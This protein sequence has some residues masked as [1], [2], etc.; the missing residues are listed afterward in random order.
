MSEPSG[1]NFSRPP[2]PPGQSSQHPAPS[3]Q[4]QQPIGVNP[5]DVGTGT[6]NNRST[7]TLY[8]GASAVNPSYSAGPPSYPPSSAQQPPLWMHG[9]EQAANFPLQPS[10]TRSGQGRGPTNA[11]NNFSQQ[12][13][14]PKITRNLA[15]SAFASPQVSP[16]PQI[17]PSPHTKNRR[18]IY[19]IR[20]R[21]ERLS[22][23]GKVISI[24]LLIAIL[25]PSIIGIFELINGIILYNQVKSGVAHIQAIQT[26][27]KG[28]DNADFSKY[29]DPTKL[30]QA[31]GEMV[32]AHSDFSL[33]SD[34]LDHDGSIGMTGLL[35]PSQIHAARSLGH[36]AM[37]ATTIGER[38]ITTATEQSPTMVKTLR[39]SAADKDT[40]HPKPYITQEAFV[41]FNQEL[42][43]LLPVIKDM[44]NHSQ[45]LSLDG[46]PLSTSQ[47]QMISALLPLIPTIYTLLSQ[48]PS[49]RNAL[50]W[51]IGADQQ[52][53]FLLEPMDSAELRSTGGFTGQFGEL[54]FN[55]G[56]MAKLQMKNIGAY[57]EDHSGPPSYGSLP[58]D[59]TL[60]QKVET[61]SAPEP[62]NA[63]WPIANFGVRDANVSGDFPTT[64]RIIMD[65]YKG[66]FGTQLSG[67]ILFTPTLIKQVLQVTGP[68]T[69]AAYGETITAQNLEAKLHYYQLDNN[70]I[71]REKAI[72]HITDPE[73]VRKAFTQRVTQAMMA[74]VMHLSIAKLVPMGTQMLQ[75]MKTKDLQVYVDNPQLESLVAKYGSTASMDVSNTHDKLD[76]VQENL[77]ANKAS[78]YVA[79]SI[80]DTVTLDQQ[81]DATH[82]LTM[83][84]NYQMRGGVYGPKTYHDYVRIYVPQNSTL[85]SGNG[86]SQLDQNPYC[87][88]PKDGY[89]ACQQD[90]YGNG[91]LVCSSAT[92]GI[93]DPTSYISGLGDTG[94]YLDKIGSPPNQT[95]DQPGH[96]MF[97]GWVIIP[98]DC[99]MAV[100]LSWTV[101]AMSQSGY[102]LMFQPQ[103]TVDPQLDLTVKSPA[104]HSG[105]TSF[106]GT[107]NGQDT[108]FR[109]KQRGNCSLQ[110]T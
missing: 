53:T 66:E 67:L 42:N 46:L 14:N 98:P 101:P 55:G 5:P 64:A 23:P 40:A 57:E 1:K 102:S 63:W 83:M 13:P 44:S 32:A 94:A 87:G 105:N 21:Y 51:L 110:R 84:L 12:R 33:L 27:F 90:V 70:G 52:R 85:I 80:K 49:V 78:Q 3:F 45:G 58:I 24:V 61:Q 18:L 71:A 2:Y 41:A 81:G 15:Q 106:S 17:N 20:N 54:T 37:D 38:F 86:F 16:L 19:R 77:S 79:T 82:S 39:A 25:L 35:L 95:S 73:L 7:G 36:I 92:V 89:P 9:Q 30:K 69:I 76:I 65:Y 99:K 43:T 103:A 100:T 88:L 28:G 104:C 68:I 4:G 56:H 72:E 31:Q 34:E 29:F 22:V 74:D 8:P 93:D 96:A 50:G 109:L 47:Y 48:G 6:N 62:F 107:M 97:G 60:Y 75:A 59:E 26:I 11:G 91:S 108:M 10:V